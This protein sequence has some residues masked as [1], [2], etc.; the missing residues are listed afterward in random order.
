VAKKKKWK[1]YDY[2][3]FWFYD[4]DQDTH[5]KCESSRIS[6]DHIQPLYVK[7]ISLTSFI[8]IYLNPSLN[9]VFQKNFI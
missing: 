8:K 9:M 2:Y 3:H 1:N 4:Q 6:S 7:M 5:W